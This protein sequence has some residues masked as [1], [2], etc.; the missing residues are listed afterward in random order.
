MPGVAG[1][2]C[3][4]PPCG[5]LGATETFSGGPGGHQ[6]LCHHE[7]CAGV[8][9]WIPGLSLQCT[10]RT[11]RFT[12]RRREP[13]H[14]Y[15]PEQ[16]SEFVKEKA[17]PLSREVGR[18][19]KVALL[20]WPVT[21]FPVKALQGAGGRPRKGQSKWGHPGKDPPPGHV[22]LLVTGTVTAFLANTLGSRKGTGRGRG[23][24]RVRAGVSPLKQTRS[25]EVIPIQSTSSCGP[26]GPFP[27][28]SP[29]Q[30]LGFTPESGWGRGAG[31]QRHS[32]S[33]FSKGCGS[34][35][36][37]ATYSRSDPR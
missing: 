22:P 1:S 3:E 34:S 17:S 14:H 10:G 30:T 9:T 15:H 12:P 35:S 25:A 8:D 32:N 23:S 7:A 11:A 31:A 37:L 18:G 19:Q 27:A 20:S 6:G 16:V 5:P 21:N 2:D 4:V 26:G 29:L 13:P 36:S 33:T 24:R 28:Q